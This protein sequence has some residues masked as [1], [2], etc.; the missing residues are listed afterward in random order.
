MKRISG[1]TCIILYAV[2]FLSLAGCSSTGKTP[3]T[4]PD[5]IIL[6]EEMSRSKVDNLFIWTLYRENDRASAYFDYNNITAFEN[7]DTYLWM[8]FIDH[9]DKDGVIYS[10]QIDCQNKYIVTLGGYFMSADGTNMIRSINRVDSVPEDE[11][12]GLNHIY[13]KYCSQDK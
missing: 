3:Y 8:K 11:T 13:K 2:I 12:K 5:M 9:I 4:P 1:L 7:G 6:T 10:L